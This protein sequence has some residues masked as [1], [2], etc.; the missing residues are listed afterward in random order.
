L[1]FRSAW[2]VLAA[3]GIYGAIGRKVAAL[4]ARA[5]DRRVTTSGIA[6]IG[7]IVRAW[8]EARQRVTLYPPQPRDP[9]L[10]TRPR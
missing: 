10:W 3:A 9:A 5:W 7:F 6:K 2:A 1:A 8:R 4:G